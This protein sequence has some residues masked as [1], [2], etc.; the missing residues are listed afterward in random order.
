MSQNSSSSQV[1]SSSAFPGSKVVVSVF[2]QVVSESVC[3][4][5][6]VAHIPWHV[7]THTAPSCCR[8]RLDLDH[9]SRQSSEAPSI[10]PRCSSLAVAK[11][12]S[13]PLDAGDCDLG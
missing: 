6:L 11:F 1:H 12:V 9:S 10:K 8:L 5:D 4:E 13:Q 3:C 7:L 2:G